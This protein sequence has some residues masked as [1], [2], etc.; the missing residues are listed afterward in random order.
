MTF[1]NFLYLFGKIANFIGWITLICFLGFI[2]LM[3]AAVAVRRYS[4]WVKIK[5]DE[6]DKEDSN[7]KKD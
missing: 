1:N 2:V 7:G 5:E 4:D 6:E 3:C